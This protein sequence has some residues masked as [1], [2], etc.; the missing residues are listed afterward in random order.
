MGKI[1]IL[2]PAGDWDMLSAAIDAGADAVYF[3]CWLNMR[4]KNFKA[5]DLPAIIKRCH[6]KGIKAYMTVNSIIYEHELEML[7]SLL[8]T[9]KD[10]GIDAIICW[11]HAV[12]EG[13]RKHGIDIHLSTQ[14][15]VANSVA[16][17]GYKKIGIARVVAARECSLSDIKKLSGKG[18]EI[19]VFI[20]GAMCVAVSGRCFMSA[21]QFNR[22]ANRGECLQPCRR[23]Y[24]I[25][26]PETGNELMVENHHVLSPKDLCTIDILDKI[27]DAGATS[28]K[29]EGRNRSPEYVRYTVSAYKEALRSISENRFD[30]DK[31]KELKDELKKVYNRGFST[32]FYLGKPIDEWCNSYGSRSTKV[33]EYVGKV[34]N[35][36][37][38]AKAAEIHI[39]AGSIHK[40]DKILIIGP[41]TGCKEMVAGSMQI[42]GE[43]V[44]AAKKGEN[45][46]LKVEDTVRKN[47]RVYVW[48]K[49]EHT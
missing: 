15:S 13:C 25:H 20:H 44:D 37:R 3:G 17:L 39:E 10:S 6:D 1:E 19:E 38:N 9:A 43:T 28:L 47:D 31:K 8:K 14:A 40:G 4:T 22:S 45:I 18:M 7:D 16:L 30:D 36:Y 41:T 11:D 21:F 26:D 42:N 24:K 33:K 48:K 2:A 35:F 12:I 49:R 29:I 32:G 46:G 23:S 34:A 27:I 5:E